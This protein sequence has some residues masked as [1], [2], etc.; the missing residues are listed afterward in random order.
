MSVNNRAYNII[1]NLEAIK[2]NSNKKFKKFLINK[3]STTVTQDEVQHLVRH[4]VLSRNFDK[5]NIVIEIY[6][7][8]ILNDLEFL[9][10]EEK[11]QFELMQHYGGCYSNNIFKKLLSKLN[12]NI[13][14][15]NREAL[16]WSVISNIL[17]NMIVLYSDKNSSRLDIFYDSCDLYSLYKLDNSLK[18]KLIFASIQIKE[19]HVF[20][21]IFETFNT[22]FSDNNT[23]NIFINIALKCNNI[24]AIGV[25][26][27]YYQF[28]ITLET[29]FEIITL[30]KN[31]ESTYNLIMLDKLFKNI[32]DLKNICNEGI[33]TVFGSQVDYAFYSHLCFL[34]TYSS[35]FIFDK[36]IGNIN[37]KYILFVIK[38]YQNFFINES[39]NKED[40]YKHIL[41]K[42]K[43]SFTK[44]LGI[45][46]I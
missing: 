14:Y 32:I 4:T 23:I 39:S 12:N 26:I 9:F 16:L 28:T 19:N 45:H 41:Q 29:L 43:E 44:I 21:K 18:N 24:Y 35:A 37:S 15:N 2:F 36:W 25:I 46:H 17:N 7:Y 27:K 6:S 30:Y 8:N 20:D 40:L 42:E 31:N 38:Y 33:N 3:L 1:K 10:Y 13:G 11:R 5:F 22:L 34:M